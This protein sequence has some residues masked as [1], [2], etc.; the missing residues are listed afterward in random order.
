MYAKAASALKQGDAASHTGPDGP[1]T[2][3]D[4]VE[5]AEGQAE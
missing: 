4:I 2:W 3:S 1:R 5:L